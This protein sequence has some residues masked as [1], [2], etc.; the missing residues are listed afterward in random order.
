MRI[1]VALILLLGCI[2]LSLMLT[3]I[4]TGLPVSHARERLSNPVAKRLGEP[5]LDA[6]EQSMN[7]P[8]RLPHDQAMQFFKRIMMEM[9]HHDYEAAAAGFT[10]FLELHPT[11][12]LAVRG[13]YW[14]GVCAYRLGHYQE[15]IEAFD[16]ALSRA[17]L[18]P[19]LAAASFLGKANSYAKL[20]DVSRSRSLLELLV[21][22]FPATDEA[23]E[24]R[25]SLLSGLH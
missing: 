23:A 14:F 4:S 16:H 9:E 25:Q 6:V 19:Q 11:S 5:W 8:A 12:P 18:D 24:A 22:Q 17:P 20:G 10:L 2:R 15:A 7:T 3:A 21:V 1:V 13:D